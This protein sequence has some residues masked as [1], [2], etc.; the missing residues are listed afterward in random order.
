MYTTSHCPHCRRAK[1]RLLRHGA[2][3][4]EHRA[5]ADEEAARRELRERFGVDTFPQIVI[6][7]RH[8]GGADELAALDRA[9][10]LVPLLR[11]SG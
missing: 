5:G 3:I 10:E 6:G 2:R 11:S 1:F 7:D 9:G 8:V 4:E